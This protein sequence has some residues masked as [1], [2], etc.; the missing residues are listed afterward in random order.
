[1]K[2]NY[3]YTDGSGSYYITIDTDLCDGCDKCM[4]A[5]PVGVLELIVDD[6]D[7]TVAAVTDEHR[8]RIKYSCA[9][10][11]PT[12]GPVVL[13][14]VAACPKEALVHSW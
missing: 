6:Y 11:K 4:T 5:C 8:R 3:G 2:A 1:M 12:S 10:C 9:P 14:C 7:D 13:P